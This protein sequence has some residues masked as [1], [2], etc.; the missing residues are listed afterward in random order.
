MNAP[1]R[2]GEIQTTAQSCVGGP[3]GHMKVRGDQEQ[4][5]RGEGGEGIHFRAAAEAQSRTAREEE[6]YVAAQAGSDVLDAASKIGCAT[7]DWKG[8]QDRGGVAGS[9]AEA[10]AHGDVLRQPKAQARGV[11]HGVEGGL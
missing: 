10:G 6:G 5:V 3:G 8:E 2:I 1:R 4:R 11:A 9:A 7:Q